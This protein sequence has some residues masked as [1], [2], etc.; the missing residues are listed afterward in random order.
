ME[1]LR[2]PKIVVGVH[3]SKI[4]T[5]SMYLQ[6]V[7]DPA[8]ATFYDHVDTAAYWCVQTQTGLGPDQEPVR[9]DLCRGGRG[10]CKL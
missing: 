4:R 6:A 5:K 2:S 7:V 10:C 8:E 3:C 9:P 1:A